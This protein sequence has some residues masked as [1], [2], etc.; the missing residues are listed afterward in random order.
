MQVIAK[1]KEADIAIKNKEIEQANAE[2]AKFRAQTV[3]EMGIA[4]A[5]VQLAMYKAYDKD[6]KMMELQLE[7]DKV[8]YNALQNFKIEMPDNLIIG[9]ADGKGAS[10]LD[11]F[12][13]LGV[14]KLL[15]E[16][17]KK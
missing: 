10:S 12:T 4:E 13:T 17:S 2:A 1:Q 15:S 16:T 7:R 3:R 11:T 5:D 9:G 6:V 8:L 14:V